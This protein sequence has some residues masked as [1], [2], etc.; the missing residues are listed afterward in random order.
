MNDIFPVLLENPSDDLLPLYLLRYSSAHTKEAYA[1]DIQ[2]LFSYLGTTRITMD[3]V[4]AVTFV[5]INHWV[6]HLEEE[7]RP[8]T[9]L[10]R[11]SAVRGFFKWLVA[12]GALERNPAD[13]AL[14]R[15]PKASRAAD[16]AISVLS[17]EHARLLVDTASRQRDRA[18]LMTLL[19][20]LL[21]RA[22][23]AAMN[24][25]HLVPSGDYW[26]LV[27]PSAKGGADQWV[28][29]PQKVVDEIRLHLE[30]DG[31]TSGPMWLSY[32]NRNTG[33][34]IS[35]RTIYNIVADTAERAGI[36]P[37]HP[38]VLRHTGCT[39]AIESGAGVQQVQ[40]HARHQSANTTLAYVHQRDRLRDSAAD[41]INF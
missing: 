10:R 28:K 20:C 16:R 5:D 35:A 13:P 4:V 15:K 24:V 19:H 14:I 41:Y 23:A 22:E 1:R 6:A 36:V 39:L 25:E 11:I 32:S 33:R 2:H 21:R 31:I 12:L 40:S 29:V 3:T 7:M 9:I 34:R 17:Q 30:A 37:T 26:Q 27:I 8:T 38:H 18:L